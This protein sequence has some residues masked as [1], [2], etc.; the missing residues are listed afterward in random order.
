MLEAPEVTLQ[1]VKSS[2]RSMGIKIYNHVPIQSRQTDR[3]LI[4]KE[5]AKNHLTLR[6]PFLFLL[7]NLQSFIL[8][9]YILIAMYATLKC[10][11][12]IKIS[13]LII[14]IINY[15]E[16]QITTQLT[17][18]QNTFLQMMYSID[19]IL[20]IGIECKLKQGCR[21]TIV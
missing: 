17:L 4:F 19:C 1:V 5:H 18:K 6:K 2:F 8:T 14:I 13:F 12:C 21:N 9:G 10:T 20:H 11:S 3:L 16:K 15:A 7:I